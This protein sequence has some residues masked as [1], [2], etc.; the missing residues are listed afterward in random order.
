M[1]SRAYIADVEQAAMSS[2]GGR[3]KTAWPHH[4]RR[5]VMQ[6]ALGCRPGEDP[7]HLREMVMKQ[8][9]AAGPQI[10]LDKNT[11][12]YHAGFLHEVRFMMPD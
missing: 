7:A 11:K 2:S 8:F 3:D 12:E 1:S 9:A 6:L 4:E 10:A 5:H